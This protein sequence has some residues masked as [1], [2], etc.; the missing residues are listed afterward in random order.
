MSANPEAMTVGLSEMLRS[1][2]GLA[3]VLERKVMT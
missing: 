2:S 3:S 1:K